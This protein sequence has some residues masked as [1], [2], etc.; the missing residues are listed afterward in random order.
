MNTGSSRI[1]REENIRVLIVLL[2]GRKYMRPYFLATAFFHALCAIV[3]LF[4]PQAMA[5]FH[6]ELFQRFP[7]F[8]V[9]FGLLFALD[10]LLLFG[11][12]RNPQNTF[13]CEAA[14]I[15]TCMLAAGWAMLGVYT[16][17]V[18]RE[19]PLRT[20]VWLY[21][22]FFHLQHSRYR[23]IPNEFRQAIDFLH[24]AKPPALPASE[25]REG[26]SCQE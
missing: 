24:N 3:L 5:L 26:Q 18:Y 7:L 16:F 22:L 25:K 9:L 19:E 21:F 15:L 11:A 20:A 12:W 10:A 6:A 2:R 14:C 17:V 4:D 8:I 13:W 23:A 1:I